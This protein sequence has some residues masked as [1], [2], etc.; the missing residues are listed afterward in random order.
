MAIKKKKYYQK[1]QMKK[2]YQ[3]EETHM[4]S[5]ME[6]LSFATGLQPEIFDED[7]FTILGLS[8]REMQRL[9]E[10]HLPKDV[11]GFGRSDFKNYI[12]M[13]LRPLDGLGHLHRFCLD[14]NDNVVGYYD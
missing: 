8:A 9:V 13:D 10:S 6:K 11:F 14:V 3:K 12:Q 5:L 2:A 4:F 1:L 7:K